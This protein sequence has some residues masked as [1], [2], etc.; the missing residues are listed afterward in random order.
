MIIQEL[1]RV[2]DHL[3]FKD[4]EE[5]SVVIRI[6]NNPDVEIEAYDILINNG[7]RKIIIEYD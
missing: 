7:D 1:K 4:D 2:L 3:K 6:I 5:Y